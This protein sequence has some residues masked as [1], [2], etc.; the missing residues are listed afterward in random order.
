MAVLA[1]DKHKHI[2]PTD[3]RRDLYHIA[4]LIEECF[5][6]TL[7]EDGREYL[8]Q[9]RKAAREME[10]LPWEPILDSNRFPGSGFV[11]EEGETII[12]NLTLIPLA[13]QKQKIFLIANVAVKAEYRG[14]G[15]GYALTSAAIE[16]ARDKGASAVWLQ[17]RE[18]NPAATHL[19]QSLGFIERARRTTWIS[20]PD[21]VQNAMPSGVKIC[22]RRSSDWAQQLAWLEEIYP[23]EV[24]WNLP[25][26]PERLKP[27]IL[28]AILKFVNDDNTTQWS[29]YIDSRLIGVLTWQPTHVHADNLWLATLPKYENTAIQSLIPYVRQKLFKH[30]PLS[31]NY[32]A[33]RAIKALQFVNFNPVHTLIWM[34]KT[35]P[36]RK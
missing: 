32:P 1:I 8:R 19:Y 7:D 18:D 27:G 33:S 21:L 2:R 12:G 15:I 6:R 16:K 24:S 17:V 26:Q 20:N 5:A 4:D 36:E 30:R 34:E 31:L 9:M 10:S 14:R 11:W 13:K 23:P 35:L 3:A 28:N 29:A 25:I 22:T